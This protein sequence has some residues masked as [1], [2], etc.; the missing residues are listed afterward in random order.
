MPE[1]GITSASLPFGRRSRILRRLGLAAIGAS[2]L[3]V[4][5][6][7]PATG[8]VPRSSFD[9]WASQPGVRVVAGDFNGDGRADIALVGGA[10]WYTVPMAFSRG[11]GTFTVTNSAVPNIP[12]WAMSSTVRPVAG[13]FNGDGRADIALVGGAGWYTVPM[14]FSRGNGTFTVTN[15]AV[16][17][18]PGWAMSSTVRP[19]AGDFNGDGRADIALVGGAGWYTVPM[20]F[21]RGN[22]TFTVTNSAVPNIPGWAMSSTVRPVAGDFNGDGRADIALVGGAG[23]Y[24]VPMAFSRGNGTFTVTNSAVPNIPGW[25]M[26]ST[27]RP[28]AG[29]FNGDGRADIALVGGAGWYTVPM[30]F[31]RGNGTFT[32]TNSAVPNI[33][34]WAMS[35]TVRPVA[36]DFNGDGRADIALVGGAGWY[37]VPM[38]FSRGNGTFTVTNAPIA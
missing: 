9:I 8:L 4:P 17:N 38:A 27:V 3:T 12:G 16:P 23:W 18:I 21:S 36:G 20:A 1:I 13:D 29:D 30:A 34:G 6:A 25:A 14:A 7:T 35:S 24:T 37:T 2:I 32:V 15:S 22:G 5:V 11:N 26:S 19:V 33:P 10:G 31:S 28:V